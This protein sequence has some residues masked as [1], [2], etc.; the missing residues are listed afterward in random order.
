M[1]T[2]TLEDEGLLVIVED[3]ASEEE[4]LDAR[5][6]GVTASE[7]HAIARGSRKRWRTLLDDKLNGSTFRGNQ[8]TR[9]GHD[10]EDALIA[11]AAHLDG[12][13]VLAPSKALFGSSE[14]QLHRATPDGLGI[15]DE[16]GHFGA[17]AKHHVEGWQNGTDAARGKRSI[18][19]VPE[20]HF[21]QC[22]WGMHVLDVDWWLYA[23]GIEGQEG[24]AGFVW[25]PRNDKRIAEL[26]AQADAFIAWRAAGAPEIDDIPDEVDDAIAEYARGLELAAE[27]EALKKAARPIIDAWT[28]T[29][30]VKEGDPL[31]KSGSRAAVF[32]EP[33]PAQ[34][35]L[36]ETKWADAEPESYAE[37]LE[38]HTRLA[39]QA[40]A[41]AVLYNR[42]KPVA[43][44][45]KV[46]PNGD[47]K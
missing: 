10:N 15:H 27:G 11:A 23:W 12:V 38:A 46:T 39:A 18:A 8:H 37:Y 31:R 28:A 16:L 1:S 45:F 34:V 7:I 47:Q 30:S 26:V 9:R 33:K 36:D 42:E 6:E 29:Q 21:N 44:T 2:V 4:W 40:S 17:E 35:V 22:Q 24:L 5:A 13:V 32:F 14:N 3:G 20:D 25:I 43:A 41:A 19:D